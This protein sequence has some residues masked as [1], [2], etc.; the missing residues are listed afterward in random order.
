MISFSRFS[1]VRSE[2]AETLFGIRPAARGTVLLEGAPLKVRVPADAIAAGIYLVP[3]DRRAQGLVLE[4][5]VRNNISLPSLKQLQR[6][7]LVAAGRGLCGG[8]E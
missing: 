6:L 7:R 2:L 3:E 4:D 5:S 1:V 8:I